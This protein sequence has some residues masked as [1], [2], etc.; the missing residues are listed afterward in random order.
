MTQ[1]I[2]ALVPEQSEVIAFHY[3]V[4]QNFLWS[5]RQPHQSFRCH[6]H[7]VCSLLGRLWY[8]FG[9][10]IFI[11][12]SL[13]MH[14]GKANLLQSFPSSVGILH[15]KQVVANKEQI[16]HAFQYQQ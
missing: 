16:K 11:C 5:R 3:F 1:I 8:H 12:W 14:A 9:K 10:H 6:S 4:F 15:W 2:I 7:S 13:Q